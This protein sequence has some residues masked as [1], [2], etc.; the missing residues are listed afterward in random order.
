MDENYLLTSYDYFLPPELIAQEPIA[1]RED[2]RLL[3]YDDKQDSIDHLHF[4]NLPQLLQPGDLLVLNRTKV[5]RAKIWGLKLSTGASVEFLLLEKL[6]GNVWKTI[7]KRS[8][9]V[10]N[11]ETFSF[12]D[13]ILTATVLDKTEEKECI[14]K[15][16]SPDNPDI[17]CDDILEELGETPLPPYI[18]LKCEHDRYQTV[19]AKE[20]GSVA[21]PT[22][23][24][25]FTPNILEQLKSKGIDTAFITLHINNGTFKPVKTDNIKD[26]PM[27]QEFYDLPPESAIKLE[28]H[29]LANKRIIA[30]GTTAFRTLETVLRKFG[31]Y[32]QDSG[33]TSLFLYPGE[34]VHCQANLITNFHLPCSTLIMLVASLIGR[35]KILNIYNEAIQ[36][37]YRFY[38]FGDAMMIWR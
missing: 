17:D 30:V 18:K 13:G 4:Y 15:F 29:R 20:R 38:S 2:S 14:L 16:Q 25:H 24:L 8:K 1:N 32:S 21:A 36:A 12:G 27:H 28:K 35:K 9:R 33:R 31:Q 37:H 6:A 7:A 5:I 11:N 23:G 3:V 10:K 26:H 34:K 19:F 22:A